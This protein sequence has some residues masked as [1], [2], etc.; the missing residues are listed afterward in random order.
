[1]IDP[2]M[3]DEFAAAFRA[4]LVEHAARTGRRRLRRL[5]LGG[6]LVLTLVLGGSAAAVASGLLPLPG[7]TVSTTLAAARTG[8]F[9]GT[10]T[11]ALDAR[12]TGADGVA[13]SFTCMT[14]GTFVFDDGASVSCSAPG[15]VQRPSTYVVPI[16]AVDG[17]GVTVTT[18]PDAVWTLTATWVSTQVTEW[19]VNEDGHSYG[20]LNDNGAP[21][22]IAVISTDG[23]AGYV[24][25]S[26]LE[27]ADGTT[28]AQSFSSPED[29][30]R[31]HADVAGTTVAI[32]V[33]AS[34]G[35][36]VIGEFD[37]T[38]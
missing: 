1:M 2:R 14:A 6:G 16:G 26:D 37:V 7:G 9:Q 33:Y 19:G 5:L 35:A 15:D 38:R 36:T 22:L 34:D 24:Y 29:A 11:L 10:A 13:L 8:T 31:W 12:P 25:R 23:K 20:A 27:D 17:D 30:L 28:A 18:S 32:P 3:S 4:R 21:D